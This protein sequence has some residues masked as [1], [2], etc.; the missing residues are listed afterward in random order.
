MVKNFRRIAIVIVSSIAAFVGLHICNNNVAANYVD[1]NIEALT[2]KE[3]EAIN[4]Y[5]C[6]MEEG[7]WSDSRTICHKGTTPTVSG[8]GTPM[9]D[10]YP[11]SGNL[12]TGALFSSL[13]YCYRKKQ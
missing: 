9:G 12:K 1:N 11:C 2:Q 8:N 7:R 6:Y 4:I 10:I 3:G 13:G 5:S